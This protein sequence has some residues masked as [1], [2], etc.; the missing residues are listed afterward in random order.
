[1]NSVWRALGL[2]TLVAAATA[3]CGGGTSA[4]TSTTS[5][6]SGQPGASATSTAPAEAAPFAVRVT[7]TPDHVFVGT[8]VTFTVE[9]RGRG[10]LSAEG[11]RFGDGGTSGANA[12]MITCGDTA[13]AD[14]VSTYTH[15]YGDPGTY[16]VRDEVSVLGPP[17]SCVPEHVTATATV[18]VAQPLPDATGGA[19]LSPTQNIACGI[20]FQSTSELQ[21]VHCATFSP[22]R[23]ADMTVSGAVTTCSGGTCSLGNPA[24]DTPVLDYGAATGVGPFLC[25]S[26]TT[27]MTCTVT[28][29]RGFTISRSGITLVG[30]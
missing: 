4:S 15:A 14:H 28:G 25:I 12:G 30:G 6:T 7:V 26:A 8:V 11:V 10:T 16:R 3:S 24:P 18:L 19:V 27:G 9:I 2:L 21:K 23:T 22:P 1:M 20:Y 17:P 29:G 13:R 5:G